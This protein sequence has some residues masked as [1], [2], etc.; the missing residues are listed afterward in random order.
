MFVSNEK[1]TGFGFF[2]SL[3][4]SSIFALILTRYPLLGTP[5]A[6]CATLYAFVFAPILLFIGNAIGCSRDDRGF[7]LD[8]RKL[9]L[10]LTSILVPLMAIVSINAVWTT[11]CTDNRGIIPILIL[12]LPPLLFGGVSGLFFGRIIGAKWPAIILS[13]AIYGGYMMSI[14]LL[15]WSHPTFYFLSHFSGMLSGD[16][17]QGFQMSPGI[18]A[19]R[20]STLVMGT[21]LS[22]SGFLFFPNVERKGLVSRSGINGW[23]FLLALTLF[24]TGVGTSIRAANEIAPS[25]FQLKKTYAY[26]ISENNILVHA[27]PN[28]TS[29]S[30]VL[31]THRE[32]ALWVKRIQNRTGLK[33]N[34]PIHVWLH[35]SKQELARFT[36]AKHVHF[37]LPSKRTIHIVGSEIPHRTLGH[38]LAHVILGQMAP[39][40]W[41][42]PGKWGLPNLGLTEALATALTQELNVLDGLSIEE[43]AGALLGQFVAGGNPSNSTDPHFREDGP[44]SAIFSSLPWRNWETHPKTSYTLGAAFILNLLASKPQTEHPN[45]WQKMAAARDMGD[46]VSDPTKSYAQF[47]KAAAKLS[48]PPHAP[49]TIEAYYQSD[50]ILV[51]QC[52]AGFD[53]EL[54]NILQLTNQERWED[55][56][57][58]AKINGKSHLF[59]RVLIDKAIVAQDYNRALKFLANTQNQN[60]PPHRLASNT[61]QKAELLWLTGRYTDARQLWSNLDESL[62]P[63][64][65]Q[66]EI[67]A[68]RIF[69]RFAMDSVG[70]LR[71]LSHASLGLLLHA[72]YS[73][74]SASKYAD[75]AQKL[76][77]INPDKLLQK[78]TEPWMLAHYLLAR[79]QSQNGSMAL[80]QQH[81]EAIHN[82]SAETKLA[83]AFEN[84]SI[85][86]KARALLEAGENTDAMLVLQSQTQLTSKGAQLAA[87]DALERI[88]AKSPD[89]GEHP[90]GL[91]ES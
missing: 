12:A 83:A 59:H 82:L 71:A 47:A 87:A 11:T 9:L 14:A 73:Q 34:A 69:S 88:L 48:L 5:G 91:R 7:G 1:K 89:H 17:L 37:A 2:Y 6:E 31:D 43:Q 30:E 40:F 41:G 32:A 74:N 78:Q 16:L 56:E 51:A 49:A 86:I 75:I 54:K 70:K 10:H 50:S 72:D 81:L 33:P 67:G 21:G 90:V 62:L 3:V 79:H 28:F 27:N 29:K 4:A 53:L 20:L 42:T 18:W 46:L 36:G 60:D 15:W 52:D 45:L 61:D 85:Q 22:L 26:T 68:K 58:R 80:A 24:G 8:L 57:T 13:A 23:I 66:R 76:A 38:E 77:S 63:P 35:P 65:R 25:R 44:L 84:E 64:H 39:T 55:A 19:Y